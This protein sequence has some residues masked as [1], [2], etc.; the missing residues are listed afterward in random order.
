MINMDMARD[1]FHGKE[2]G[3]G[4]RKIQAKSVN[5]GSLNEGILVDIE[6][7]VYRIFNKTR[8]EKDKKEGFRREMVLGDDHENIRITLWDKQADLVDNLAVERGDKVRISNA[9]V[10]RFNGGL[11]LSGTAGTNVARVSPSATGI[12][13][14]SA[15]GPESKN[16][17]VICRVVSIGR[18]RYFMD[19]SGKQSAVS[20]CIVS[21]SKE[22]ARLVMWR[23]SA[24]YAALMRP[25]GFIKVEQAAIKATNAGMEIIADDLSR[26][27]IN[28]SLGRRLNAV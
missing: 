23:S 3:N 26:I 19:L 17:D 9:K 4:N 10:K 1:I 25:G 5:A 15:L 18:I 2:P 27:L 7:N 11:E 24:A 16:V 22:Q 14:F 20:D 28:D 12:T 21:D 8:F 13:E 6:D